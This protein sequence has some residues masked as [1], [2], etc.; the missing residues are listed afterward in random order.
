[1]QITFGLTPG[2]L[3]LYCLLVYL[4]LSGPVVAWLI[5]HPGHPREY[6]RIMAGYL[7]APILF[8]LAILFGVA[9]AGSMI[10]A[11]ILLVVLLGLCMPFC[12]LRDLFDISPTFDLEFLLV[13]G[14]LR[15]WQFIFGPD[16][17]DRP[18]L[19]QA[20]RRSP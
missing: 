17:K 1:M 19:E 15:H 18:T 12:V 20:F 7:F 10:A 6:R 3:G 16:K 4:L 11:G 14:L 5:K 2:M 9:L 8:P 13:R